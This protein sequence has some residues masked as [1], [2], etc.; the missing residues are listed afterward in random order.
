MK[1]EVD[2]LEDELR[3]EYDFSKMVGGVKGKYV[4]RY[5]TG[6]NL[7][8]LDPDVAQAF[9][10][11]LSVNEALRLLLQIAQRQQSTSSAGTD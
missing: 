3:P 10:T 11:D 8:L 1:K 2:E 5:R 7:V 4:E 9:P 6:T